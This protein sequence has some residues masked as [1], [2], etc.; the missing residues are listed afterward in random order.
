MRKASDRLC[1]EYSLSV[2][3][4]P[5]EDRSKHY[6]EWKAGQE[7]KPTWGGLIREDVDKVIFASMTFTQFIATLRK[8]G[9]EVKTGVKYIAVRRRARNGLSG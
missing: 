3:E 4:N 7:G 5:Q 2:I 6:A 1:K 9:Y 8:Q